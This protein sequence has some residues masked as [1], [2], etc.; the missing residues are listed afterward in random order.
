M[1]LVNDIS[2]I[3]LTTDETAKYLGRTRKAIWELVSKGVLE[4]RKFGG[5]LYF[6]KSDLDLMIENI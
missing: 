4:K 2:K 5:R 3:W 1:N 6:K